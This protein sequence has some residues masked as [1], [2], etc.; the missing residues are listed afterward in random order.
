MRC[1][2]CTSHTLTHFLATCSNVAVNDVFHFGGDLLVPCAVVIGPPG[3]LRSNQTDRRLLDL[4][5]GS[6]LL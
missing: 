1:T 3:A 5:P 6:W 2:V 4:F